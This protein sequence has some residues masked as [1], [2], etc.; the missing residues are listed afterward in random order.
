MV[1]LALHLFV[2]NGRWQLIPVYALTFA[3]SIVLAVPKSGAYRAGGLVTRIATAV[4]LVVPALLLALAVPMFLVPEPTGPHG[5]GVVSLGFV[6]DGEPVTV[7]YPLDVERRRG[8]QLAAPYWTADEVGAYSLPGLPRL[9][10]SHLTLVRTNSVLRGRR[11]DGEFPVAI[12]FTGPDRLPS[13]YLT[14]TEQVASLG[15]IVLEVP[16]RAQPDDILN[17]LANLDRGIVDSAFE[18]AIDEDRIVV[19]GMGVEPEQ[20]LGVP[21]VTVGVNPLLSVVTPDAT[22]GMA[23]P[24]ARIPSAAAT[25]RYLIVRPSRFLVGSSDVR[26]ED[27]VRLLAAAVSAVLGSGGLPAPVFSGEPAGEALAGTQAA[28]AEVLGGLSIIPLPRGQR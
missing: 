2:E 13:D 1:V 21:S 15:W 28:F 23:L 3:L 25:N 27:L 8:I 20:S 5:V 16:Q 14:I 18:G 24:D 17:F 10:S 7:R 19:L 12:A 6:P 9:A 4:F 11:A 22:Y 26:S